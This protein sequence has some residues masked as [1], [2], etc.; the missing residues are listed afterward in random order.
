MLISCR[1]ARCFSI[2]CANINIIFA[3]SC[4]HQE[5]SVKKLLWSL[6]APQYCEIRYYY[7]A[8]YTSCNQH[9]LLQSAL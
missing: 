2:I 1:I 5:K 8:R 7:F 9:D 3:L 6:K 4:I